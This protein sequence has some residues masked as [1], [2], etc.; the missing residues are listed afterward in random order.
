M[1][2]IIF[3]LP[4]LLLTFTSLKDDALLK[5]PFCKLIEEADYEGFHGMLTP[6]LIPDVEFVCKLPLY[7]WMMRTL[8]SF[9]EI[10]KIGDPLT[11]CFLT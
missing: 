5:F 10:Y 9:H 6:E 2:K 1:I 11:L 8:P 3:F 4:L 7:N